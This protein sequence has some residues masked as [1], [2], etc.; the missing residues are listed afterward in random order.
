MCWTVEK[1]IFES[2][3][4]VSLL[5]IDLAGPS[6]MKFSRKLISIV[7]CDFYGI[8]LFIF[9]LFISSHRVGMMIWCWKSRSLSSN[10]VVKLFLI[11]LRDFAAGST[12]E[13]MTDEWIIQSQSTIQKKLYFFHSLN[14]YHRFDLERA[15]KDFCKPF[16]VHLNFHRRRWNDG[17]KFN[18]HW[19]DE[20]TKLLYFFLFSSLPSS[21]IDPKLID[22]DASID[23]IFSPKI[24]D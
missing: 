2:F 24:T 6:W 18:C 9:S 20:I 22:S 15:L 23:D 7:S 8:F 1:E 12:E 21:K 4:W 17:N 11:L 19:K 14:Q 16:F 3:E 13:P 10:I 5:R